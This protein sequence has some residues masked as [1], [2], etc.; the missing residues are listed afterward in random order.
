[1]KEVTMST[2]ESDTERQAR[3][4]ADIRRLF[5]RYRRASNP[6]GPERLEEHES[7]IRRPAGGRFSSDARPVGSARFNDPPRAR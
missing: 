7:V 1:M 4:E 2:S 6:D 5:A 3:I